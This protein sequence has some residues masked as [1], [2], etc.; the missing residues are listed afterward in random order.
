[1]SVEFKIRRGFLL[2]LFLCLSAHSAIIFSQKVLFPEW[3][4]PYSRFDN[5]TIMA[6]KAGVETRSLLQDS[7]GF[8]W[9]GNQSGLYQ[10]D[11]II[12]KRIGFGEDN[13]TT[14]SGICVL[15]IYEDPQGILWI[16]TIGYLNRIDR[17]SGRISHF[18]PDST[19]PADFNNT[20]R[21]INE[22][23]HGILWLI[24]DKDVYSFN[25]E[26]CAFTRFPINPL[27]W[28]TIIS[29]LVIEEDRFAED[30]KGRIWIATNDG[31][32]CF[33]HN[34][35]TWKKVFPSGE[36]P[37]NKDN[38]KINSVTCDLSGKVWIGTENMGVIE[39]IDPEKGSWKQVDLPVYQGINSLRRK[40]DSVY[41]DSAGTIWAFGESRLSK[42]FSD[43]GETSSFLFSDEHG[44]RK[45]DNNLVIHKILTGDNG[46]LWL[47]S[48]DRGL[49]FRF[50]IDSEKLTIYGV[51]R[52]IDFAFIKDFSGS[53]WI[54][55]ISPAI[56]R[57]VT[58]SLQFFQVKV[59]YN[60]TPN[61]QPRFRIA[62]D[63]KENVW[64]GMENG[65]FHFN[66]G[67]LGTIDSPKI[68][69]TPQMDF[70]TTC[71]FHDSK[72]NLWFGTRDNI[73]MK[74]SPENKL[75]TEYALSGEHITSPGEWIIKITEDKSGTIWLCHSK[76]GI[77]RLMP[78]E[79]TVKSFIDKNE[80]D[81][82]E[83]GIE[84]V[85]FIIDNNDNLWISTLGNIYRTDMNKT[86]IRDFSGFDGTGQ[87]YGN[88]YNRMVTDNDGKIW[89]LNAQ[90]GPYFF[91]QEDETFTRIRIGEE[92][93]GI[94]FTDLIFDNRNNLWLTQNNS[95][96][97]VNPVSGRTRKI[98][99]FPNLQVDVQ[100]WRL[101]S[102]EMI[103]L[104][105]RYLYIFPENVPVNRSVPEIY[106]TG[107]YI[108]G[109]SFN[110]IFPDRELIPD[111]KKIELSHKNN[112]LK[113]EFTALN[114]YYPEMN[115][116]RYFMKGIDTDTSGVV[117]AKSIEYRKMP[118]GRYTFWVTG[119]NND[120]IWN[121]TGTSLYIRIRPPF[122]RSTLAY[123]VYFLL[124]T[125]S[126]VIYIH[127]RTLRLTR[128]KIRLEI[129]VR[130][131]TRE[132]E[133]KNSLLED[134]DQTKTRFFT[135]IS[136]EIR[137]P[138]SLILSPLENLRREHQ[139]SDKE[140]NILEMMERNG[141]RLM[142]LVSQLLDISRLDSGKMKIILSEGDIIKTIRIL[143]YEFLSVAESLRI[144]YIVEIPETGLITFF[145]QDK[146]EKI[147]S[148]L[149]SNAFKFTPEE[150][151]VI[152]RVRLD[153]E[154]PEK[155]DQILEINV[156]DTG[157]GIPREHLDKI[158]D[159]FYRVEGNSAVSKQGTGIGLSLSQEFVS[160]LHGTIE[161]RTNPGKGSEFIVRI[162]LGKKH[163]KKDEF[164]IAESDIKEIRK[165][166]KLSQREIENE[167]VR[168]E[169]GREKILV[170]EDNTD[171]R[172]F[173]R[174]SLCDD[175][176]IVEAENGRKGINIAFTTIP[177]LIVTDLMMPDIEGNELCSK[178]KSD[179]KTSHIPVIMLTAKA[180][181]DDKLQGL[182]TGADDYIIKPFSL[183]ELKVRIANLL[184]QREKLRLKYRDHR[185]F[186]GLEPHELSVDDKFMG[187]V[188]KIISENIG[189]FDFDSSTLHEMLGMSRV[190]LFRKLKALT[191][192][193]PSIFI[194]NARLEK[195]ARLLIENTGNITE[196]ANSVGISN[197]SYF[198][199]CFRN[200]FKMSPKN[201][202]RLK[203]TSASFL[204]G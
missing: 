73:L 62:E 112:Y 100:S 203:G 174:E 110:K 184:E 24:T 28:R 194:R 23:S 47:I 27:G 53:F 181:M 120:G 21:L 95:L 157:P 46:D 131:R 50:A 86:R 101:K 83:T 15:D 149:L 107:V 102:G 33:N 22:D 51:P 54:G 52:F 3:Y 103:Y 151:Q 185:S 63:N 169:E 13:D 64:L 187:K 136:H 111:L 119:S 89:V 94:Y 14:L 166:W 180:T 154:N 20:I 74:F 164:V 39:I 93:Y 196:V 117:S 197:P 195:S 98:T 105:D 168:Q 125:A 106:L 130:E 9:C 173:I 92:F 192:L 77:F 49:V 16:G 91:N 116:Y 7:K 66:T 11:G 176:Y 76:S 61:I 138:L 145:D 182:R 2:S 60:S 135:N 188:N 30:M 87:A 35:K 179:E 115:R 71:I 96:I 189:N 171:M 132:L 40:I 99:P 104:W 191:G 165:S 175:Y 193:P 204:T 5:F 144:R 81:S 172:D 156:S 155:T 121:K 129:E 25:K 90:K 123:I 109:K 43:S 18:L 65:L 167:Q 190:H 78:G 10:F 88:F 143:V 137:T 17:K 198:T 8:I 80:L 85:D 45:W 134:M 32:Y 79:K 37:G 31:L 150:G 128:E 68:I 19:N 162:P 158:F 82:D 126:L 161:V 140:R 4:P 159:R 56:H 58:D 55:S 44:K 152:C 124:F 200:H 133:C 183:S 114:Y 160:L 202:A 146:T 84:I 75:L 38:C 6:G 57:L 141:Q 36:A 41:C 127:L 113:L 201:Y 153:F 142:H 148:N 42:I 97:I 147:I 1:M 69:K 163:L 122:Y 29:P 70:R 108:N 178:I 139:G 177:D 59:A 26:S 72:D 48:M 170:V 34:D 186:E 118:P 67:D 12:F 199:K